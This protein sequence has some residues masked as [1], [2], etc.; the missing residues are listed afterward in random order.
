MF[1]YYCADKYSTEGF[2]AVLSSDTDNIALSHLGGMK[3]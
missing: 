3:S 2:V 1:N